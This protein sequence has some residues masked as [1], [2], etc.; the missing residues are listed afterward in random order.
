MKINV[1]KFQDGGAAPAAAP[2]PDAQAQGAQPQEGGAPEG[3]QDPL[4]QIAQ[5]FQQGLQNQD[6]GALSQGAQLFM[7]VIQQAQAQQGGAAPQ[8]AAPEQ[9]GTQPVYKK[10]GKFAKRI[11]KDSDPN[12]VENACKGTKMKKK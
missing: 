10:G 12:S 3:G 7:Q 2:A 11:S 6:C 8:G 9:G 5:L 4:M 1:S